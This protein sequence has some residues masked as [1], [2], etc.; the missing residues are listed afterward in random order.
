MKKVIS[1][2]FLFA[3]VFGMQAQKSEIGAFAGT[4]FYLGELN[5]TTLFAQPSV[6]GGILYRYNITPRWAVR[7]TI[8]FANVS[9][10]D[11]NTNKQ[12][13]RGLDFHSPITEIAVQGELNFF[14]IYNQSGENRFTPYICTGIV[15]FSFN[16]QTEY[17]GQTYALQHLGTEGQGLPG[18]KNYYSLTSVAIPFGIGLK[19]NIG[20]FISLGVEWG[21]RYTFTDYLD[22]VGGTYYDNQ[23]LAKERGDV[24]AALADRSETLHKAG[25]GRGNSTTHDLYSFLGGSVTFKFGNEDQSCNI[26]R[27][28]NIRKRLGKKH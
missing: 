5:P 10:S 22:D 1:F 23:V 12:Y 2:I 19:V 20:K 9:A 8:I 28:I 15:V 18:G 14:N 7:A 4:S 6:A 25:T 27:H 11:A 26:R 24:V 13:E 16:P 21:M 17:N 3:I